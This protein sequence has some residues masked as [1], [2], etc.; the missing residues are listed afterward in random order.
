MVRL[1]VSHGVTHK[2]QSEEVPTVLIKVS[3]DEVRGNYRERERRVMLLLPSITHNVPLF[4][5]SIGLTQ[6]ADRLVCRTNT[7]ET[8]VSAQMKGWLTCK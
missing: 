3:P 4:S 7:E 2:E 5:G 6:R 8:T 1:V